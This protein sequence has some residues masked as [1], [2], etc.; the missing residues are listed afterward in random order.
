MSISFAHHIPLIG[1]LTPAQV[2]FS[3]LLST[4]SLPRVLYGPLNEL[5]VLLVACRRS[6]YWNG[7]SL[8]ITGTYPADATAPASAER[9]I[10]RSP[11]IV[12]MKRDVNHLLCM[13][14][15]DVP[16][17]KD[18]GTS[19]SHAQSGHGTTWYCSLSAGFLNACITVLI[20][21]TL[22]RYIG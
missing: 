5:G 22:R 15:R 12:S 19:V 4:M 1:Q 10:V 14:W 11:N 3:P 18:L 21:V 2:T 6:L 7:A 9:N 16:T 17:F 20:I 8:D 13:N